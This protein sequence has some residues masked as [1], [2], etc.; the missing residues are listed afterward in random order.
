MFDYQ[1][2]TPPTTTSGRP[3]QAPKPVI[4]GDIVA[5][6]AATGRGTWTSFTVG[7]KGSNPADPYDASI[8]D[9]TRDLARSARAAN[10]TI[11]YKVFN[12]ATGEHV[13]LTDKAT[14]QT[15]DQVLT[16]Q[17]VPA[18]IAFDARPKG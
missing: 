13:P 14:S 6:N 5:A 11:T 15:A 9:H 8:A 3:G 17:G 18:L 16:E 4:H 2:Y 10:A 7:P 12:A 1:P